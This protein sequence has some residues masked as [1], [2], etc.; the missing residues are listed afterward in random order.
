MVWGHECLRMRAR[1]IITAVIIVSLIGSFNKA[2]YFLINALYAACLWSRTCWYLTGLLSFGAKKES[3]LQVDLPCLY[4]CHKV[5]IIETGRF[6]VALF[7]R[8][9]KRWI[10]TM[11]LCICYSPE[12]SSAKS[13]SVR[14][15]A[16][17]QSSRS[18]VNV[19]PSVAVSWIHSVKILI[20]V[21]RC[22]APRCWS[23]FFRL[24]NQ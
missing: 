12:R 15:W 8:I 1:V 13:K 24:K 23:Q 22:F 6:P 21:W 20:A 7:R 5:L 19:A 16:A 3:S 18:K 10:V 9:D 17:K 4:G 2:T 14:H 11:T